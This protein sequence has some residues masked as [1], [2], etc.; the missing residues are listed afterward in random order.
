MI[1]YTIPVIIAIILSGFIMEVIDAS[2]GMG[3][4]TVLTPIL[5]MV[6]FDPY[7]VVP[8]VLI[9]QLI[10]DWSAV[11]FHQKFKNID[12]MEDDRK[13]L[14][15]AT[16]L[17]VLSCLGAVLA[18]IIVVNISTFF[19]S[20]Y[21]GLMVTAI[22]FVLYW[23][24]NKTYGFSTTKLVIIGFVAAFNKAMSGGGYG[25]L[26][27]G[28]QILSG[29]NE[30]AS[31]AIT[32]LV[33]GIICIVSVLTY[34]ITGRVIDWS[35]TLYLSIAVGLSAPVSAFLI[36]KVESKRLKLIISIST[37]TLGIFTLIKLFI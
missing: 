3:Y 36:S 20:L 12:F 14:K 16:L 37:A 26:V 2:L 6:G 34:L 35:L 22:G 33:E 1:S 9:S 31:V 17:G 30:K 8:A 11:F 4:G 24:R 15:T 32:S 23:T 19:L 7:Q 25:P 18:V 29:V 28:G 10:G 13:A 27:T 5:L 21:I